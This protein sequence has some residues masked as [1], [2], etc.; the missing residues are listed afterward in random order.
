ML[1]DFDGLTIIIGV[2]FYIFVC[3]IIYENFIKNKQ[4]FADFHGCI[5]RRLIRC[6]FE[7]G[8][9]DEIVELAEKSLKICGN[10]GDISITYRIQGELLNYFSENDFFSKDELKEQ[11]LESARK[12]YYLSKI[13]QDKK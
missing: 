6:L 8:Q 3:V 12:M 1:V 11:C 9:C 10:I 4:V 13:Y 2:I 7:Q 5:T